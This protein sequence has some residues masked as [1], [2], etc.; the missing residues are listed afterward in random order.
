MWLIR[1]RLNDWRFNDDK[2]WINDRAWLDD[3]LWFEMSVRNT[4][5]IWIH[6]RMGMSNWAGLNYW[7]DDWLGFVGWVYDNL[8]FGCD[9]LRIVRTRLDDT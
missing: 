2:A 1:T 6:G 5:M 4:G 7:V 9:K 3:N 8:W